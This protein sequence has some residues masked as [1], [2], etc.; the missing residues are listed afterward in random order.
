VQNLICTN[1]FIQITLWSM[2]LKISKLLVL[3]YL[4]FFWG[5]LSLIVVHVCSNA[6]SL[7][8]VN[9]FQIYFGRIFLSVCEGQVYTGTDADSWR[10]ICCRR[11]LYVCSVFRLVAAVDVSRDPWHPL[12]SFLILFVI[13]LPICLCYTGICF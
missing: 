8:Q 9:H 1:C 6:V 5:F 12:W 7:K 3:Q 10:Q 13:L 2:L 11:P 4:I